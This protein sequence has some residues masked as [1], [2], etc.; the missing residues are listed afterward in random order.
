MERVTKGQ[1]VTGEEIA[2]TIHTCGPSSS[3]CKCQCPDGPCDHDFR[4]CVDQGNGCYSAVCTKCGL[5]AIQHS[6]WVEP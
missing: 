2:I 6:L 1:E 3:T 4:G 5:P